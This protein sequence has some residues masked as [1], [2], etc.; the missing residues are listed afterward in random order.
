MLAVRKIFAEAVNSVAEP[1][2]HSL[3][4]RLVATAARG[5]RDAR[6]ELFERYRLA[7][8]HVAYRV[9][10]READALDVVQESF[11]RAFERLG[12]FRGTSGETKTNSGAGEPSETTERRAAGAAATTLPGARAAG[13]AAATVPDALAAGAAAATVPDAPSGTGFKTWL[14]RIVTNRALDLV[15]ARRVRRAMSLDGDE[16]DPVAQPADDDTD[17]QPGHRLEQA[18]LAEQLRAAIAQLPPEQRAVVSLYA[19]GEMTYGQIAEV[20]G[21]PIGTVMSRLFNARRRLATMLPG[22]GASEEVR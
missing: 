16:D 4:E 9:T 19:T 18:E 1:N 14:L 7:A 22:L 10:G 17:S 20:L 11:I 13:A 3:E 21:V 12:Q 5:D 2:V 15:R 8:Y 6:R